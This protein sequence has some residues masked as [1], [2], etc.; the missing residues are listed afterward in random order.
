[1][2][3][4]I[5]NWLHL[6]L[7][8]ISGIIMFVVCLT[9]AVWVFADDIRDLID[10]PII[11]DKQHKPI[12]SPSDISGIVHRLYP[13][14]PINTVFY[15]DGSA[16]EVLIR[17]WGNDPLLVFL[18]PYTGKVLYKRILEDR[19]TLFFYWIEAGH[20]N[21]WLPFKLGRA[22][23]NYGTL[24]FVVLLITGLIWWYPKKWNRSTRNKSFKIKW[25]AKWKRINIDL[26]N[27]LGFYALLILLLLSLTG[28]IYGIKW[29]SNG[30]YL[31]T[32]GNS[33]P[34]WSAPASDSTAL[35]TLK[36]EAALDLAMGKV[37]KRFPLSA[38]YFFRMPDS[39]DLK[40]AIEI[41]V[42]PKLNSY[43][44]NQNF[45][46]DR[47]TAEEIARPA[48][49][50]ESFE[51]AGTG[52]K[53]RRMNYDIHVGRILGFPGKIIAFFASLIGA[54]LP[55][56]GFIIWYNRKFGKKSKKR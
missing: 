3:R 27:V 22:V 48:Y 47:Y 50:A 18:D 38:G 19:L 51:E 10:P 11:V 1:M 49:Y 29:Y 55:V 45:C 14:E 44:A 16:V 4:K 17:K 30:V 33:M 35:K 37:R 46:F 40:A 20:R 39:L 42:Y 34:E 5:N 13:G 26:H 7:G 28:M 24:I 9:G 31:A 8:L 41:D 2:F 32:T 21:L 54:S 25:E 43:Y 53:I 6:W 12:I 15:K 36:L 52:L 56:T 23:V